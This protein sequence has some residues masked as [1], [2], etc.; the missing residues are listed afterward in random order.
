[1]PTQ[2]S[3]AVSLAIGSILLVAGI[4]SLIY[5]L[6]LHKHPVFGRAVMSFFRAWRR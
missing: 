3:G 1:M 5:E 6:G 2:T 4:G